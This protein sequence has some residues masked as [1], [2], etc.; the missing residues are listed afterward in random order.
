MGLL[1]TPKLSW[2]EAQEKLACQAQRPFNAISHFQKPFGYF[3]IKDFFSRFLIL[4][5]NMVNKINKERR[6]SMNANFM[7]RISSMGV[8]I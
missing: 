1:F 3:P 5:S 2:N 7:L 6:R 4:V 8:S